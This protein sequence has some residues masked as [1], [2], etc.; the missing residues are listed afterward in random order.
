M[1]AFSGP[2]VEDRTELEPFDALFAADLPEELLLSTLIEAIDRAADDDRIS[3]IVL[4]LENMA[5]PS[6]SQTMEILE[7]V[8]RFKAS[9]K[10]ILA[11]ADYLSQSQYLLA[12][13]AD[14]IVMHPEGGVMLTGFG[15]Y[16]T[17]MKRFLDNIKVN[18]HVFRVGEN[19]S[20]VEPY[21]RDDMSESQREVVGQWLGSMWQDYASIV[22]T[23]RG[24]E[25]GSLNSLINDFP[26]RLTANRGDLAEA[27]LEAGLI[28]QIL[29]HDEI[30]EWLS[31]RVGATD[32]SG[33]AELVG[34][35]RYVTDY[36]SKA[37]ASDDPVIAVVAIEGSLMPGSSG[38]GVAGSESIV[39]HLER[40][41]DDD[42]AALVVRI[43][44]GGGSVFASEVI[45]AKIEAIASSGVPVIASMGGAAASGGYWI[46]SQA[47]EIWAMPTT[48]TGSIGVWSI[49]PT[50]EGLMDYAGL[51][52]DGVGTTELAASFDASRPLDDAS[53]QIFQAIVDGIYEDFIDLVSERRS[54]S[55]EVVDAIAGGK[56]WIGR[57]AIE[58]GLVDQLGSL[59]DAVAAAAK[60]AGV[61]EA[62]QTVRYG[63]EVSPQQLVLEEL[64]RNF[65]LAGA[66]GWS[67][68]WQWLAPLRQQ[69]AFI[70][71]LRDPRHV[72]LHC[73]DCN[74]VY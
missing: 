10:P 52:V 63:T 70:D 16:R 36:R 6:T 14:E 66:Q 21:M 74:Y 9:G 23:G 12:S 53:A 38:Q 29:D 42:V 56:V 37:K 46:A 27:M 40:A 35:R 3:S 18:F 15:V 1:I 41:Y 30:E 20:A 26:Q 34:L 28:D 69:L 39:D 2:L 17:Y 22:E 60:T 67:Y 19:K 47:D 68:V 71:T 55:T 51:S 5:G 4:N 50:V 11:Y 13:V 57:D 25:A 59:D 43:N 44:S 32:S 61:D 45:R 7:A 58:I 49:F 8:D 24:L 62:Y 31:E 48:I 73:L 33:D 65:G 72:Y 64:G 54:M